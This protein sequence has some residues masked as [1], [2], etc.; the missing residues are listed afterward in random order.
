MTGHTAA[1]GIGTVGQLRRLLAGLAD[2]AALRAE[3]WL[4]G[5]LVS[6]VGDAAVDGGVLLLVAVE[7]VGRNTAVPSAPRREQVP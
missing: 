3:D 7:A 4:S 2:E 1:T 6:L 5:R